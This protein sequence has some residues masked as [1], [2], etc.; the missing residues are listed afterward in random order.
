MANSP[1]K[2]SLQKRDLSHVSPT[3]E[4]FLKVPV[5]IYWWKACSLGP[6]VPTQPTSQ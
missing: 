3:R 1:K 5:H 6:P 2:T 4:P